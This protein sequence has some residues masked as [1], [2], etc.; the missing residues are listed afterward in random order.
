MR[1]GVRPT[2]PK[3]FARKPTLSQEVPNFGRT[4]ATC[5]L[6]EMPWPGAVQGDAAAQA[7]PRPTDLLK[8]LGPGPL[9]QGL[10]A[11]LEEHSA[12]ALVLGTH[13]LHAP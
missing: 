9:L 4:P 1:G 8:G 11:E 2:R 12:A 6:G 5:K 7:P 13:D 3:T 10:L